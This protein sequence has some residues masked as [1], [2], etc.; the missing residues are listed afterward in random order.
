MTRGETVHL[1]LQKERLEVLAPV[2]SETEIILFEILSESGVSSD[3][4]TLVSF[5]SYWVEPLSEWEQLFRFSSVMSSFCLHSVRWSL[6][7]QSGLDCR[8][9][10]AASQM[11]CYL[12][13]S[14]LLGPTYCKHCLM[15]VEK[16]YDVVRTGAE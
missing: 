9:D 13:H 11:S 4:I 8:F 15:I 12:C 2:M 1:L 14:L 6:A 16:D 5:R 7:L 10:L 3:L